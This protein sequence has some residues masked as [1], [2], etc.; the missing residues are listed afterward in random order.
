M[1]DFKKAIISSVSFVLLIV[2]FSVCIIEPYYHTDYYSFTDR[3]YRDTL[4]GSIDYVII[5]SSHAMTAFCPSIID[6]K[7]NCNSY[8]LSGSLMTF[9]GRE[10]LLK[11]EL[12]RNPVKNVIIEVAYNALSRDEYDAEGNMYLLPRLNGAKNRFK[13]LFENEILSNYDLIYSNDLGCG[14]TVCER[15]AYLLIKNYD[16]ENLKDIIS[17]GCS[18]YPYNKDCNLRTTKNNVSLEGQN[19]IDN[20]NIEYIPKDYNEDNIDT[21]ERMIDICNENNINVRLVVTPISDSEIWEYDGWDYFY[22]YMKN[23]SEKNN[24]SFF[25]FNLLKSRYSLFD[26]KDTFSD[27]HHMCEEGAKIFTNEFCSI[28]NYVNSGDSIDDLF[29]SSYEEMKADSP[30]MEY[31]STHN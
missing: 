30:Y 1:R 14:L 25:D 28:T 8:N 4:A 12:V 6:E 22:D 13:Y 23:F 27:N 31:Y 7:L 18:N 5:G 15:I 26:D 9:R 29:Y 19:I 16:K 11:E 10:E 17:S 24:V 2:I 20:Y 3:K 21:I